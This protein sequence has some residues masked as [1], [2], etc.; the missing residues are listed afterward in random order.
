MTFSAYIEYDPET[1]L[2]AGVVPGIS[3]A[4]SQGSTLDE[5]KTNLTEV[6]ELI[7]E[8]SKSR[9]EL[10]SLPRLLGV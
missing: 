5:L 2:F 3:G 10:E 4:H 7:V 9:G 8:E 6:L 1:K